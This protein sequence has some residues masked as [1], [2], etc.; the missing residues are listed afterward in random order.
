VHRNAPRSEWRAEYQDLRDGLPRTIRFASADGR[1]DL[2]L[3]LSQV[4]V[5]VPLGPDAFRVPIPPSAVPI[6]VNELRESGPL[7]AGA[8][9][10]GR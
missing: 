1:V 4:E 10:H 6:S 7:A 9:S 2:R 3:T 8:A 5:N